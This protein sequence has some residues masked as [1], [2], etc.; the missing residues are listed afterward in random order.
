MGRESMLR[1]V[2][3]VEDS[4]G[5]T[6]LIREF[7]SGHMTVIRAATLAE[8]SRLARTDL[9]AVALVD[10]SLPDAQGGQAIDALARE[11]G[12]PVIL[13]TPTDIAELGRTAAECGAHDYLVKGQFSAS[14]LLRTIS[15]AVYRY[16]SLM[17]YR[18]LSHE[19]PDGV[20]IVSDGG[21]VLFANPSALRA[22]DLPSGGLVGSGF[23]APMAGGATTELTLPNGRTMEMRVGRVQWED[24][25]AYLTVLR[26][27][28]DRVRLVAELADANEKLATLSIVDPLT[29]VLNRRGIEDAFQRIIRASVRGGGG[30]VALLIDCDDFKAVN[31]AVGY[32]AGDATLQLVAQTVASGIRTS[33]DCVGRIGGDEFLVLLPDTRF[34]EG[35]LVAER[36]CEAIG[37]KVLPVSVPGLHGHLSVSIGAVVV[38]HTVVCMKEV[39]ALAE[40][41]LRASKHS[42]KGR[43]TP[44]EGDG[45]N[46][47]D[48]REVISGVQAM[49][50]FAQP[51]VSHPSAT[52]VGHELFFRGPVASLIEVPVMFFAAA[53]RH[54]LLAGADLAC[55]R[56]CLEV[57]SH[58]TK[59]GRLHLNM[60]PSTL[61]NTPL[62]EVLKL[63]TTTQHLVLEL[64]E[65]EFVG[66]PSLLSPALAAL[67]Q[68]G[69]LIALDDVGFGRSS[70]EAILVVEPDLIKIDRCM[71]HGIAEDV[72][73]RRRLRRLLQCLEGLGAEIIAKGIE[74]EADANVIGE[75]GIRFAQGFFWGRPEAVKGPADGGGGKT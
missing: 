3:V 9:F 4:D 16:A 52:V 26:D 19:S 14:R 70:L 46:S 23:G 63:F 2:L 38:P 35:L 61:L 66:D 10:A 57:G 62:E 20:L 42:G 45:G 37:R 68:A 6:D 15:F 21:I 51:V 13:V 74:S 64:N 36:L 8:A 17:Q 48:V 71:G 32:V 58:L 11:G 12:F 56:R 27:V 31:S 1:R 60:F 30:A 7:L 41:A 49:R 24:A 69:V 28:T 44:G 43:V 55:L 22:F 53:R 54:N 34:A 59:Q 73:Q 47:T 18:A 75:L 50:I 25:E 72:G 67:K 33:F 40:P 5:D 29:G 65:Q 39:V